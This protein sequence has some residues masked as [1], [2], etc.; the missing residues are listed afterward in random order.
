VVK[1]AFGP[2]VVAAL[3]AS[4]IWL[5]RARAIRGVAPTD[6][7]LLL[8]QLEHSRVVDEKPRTFGERIVDFLGRA[9]AGL[10]G[11]AFGA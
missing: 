4:I 9:L 5:R 8:E 3:I 1:D 7:D 2:A 10:V 11:A 6:P